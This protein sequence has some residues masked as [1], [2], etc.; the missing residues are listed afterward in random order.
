M[1]IALLNLPLDNNYGGNLQRF[2][3][4]RT[5]QKMGY[6]I[7]FLFCVPPIVTFSYIRAPF[8]Y[9]KRIILRYILMKKNVH[10][11]QESFQLKESEN[12]LKDEVRFMKSH[13]KVSQIIYSKKDLVAFAKDEVFDCYIVGSDQVW[14]KSI[15]HEYGISTYFLDFLPKRFR[16]KR[17]A[18]AVSFGTDSNELNEYDITKLGILY[19]KFDAISLRESSGINLIKSYKWNGVQPISLIDPTFLITK[20]EYINEI[21]KV[22]TVS[23]NGDIFC[24]ILDY[25]LEKENVIQTL[26]DK[27][28]MKPYLCC[29]QNSNKVSIEQW[30][31]FFYEAKFIVTDS[32]HGIVFSIIFNK[33]FKLLI[34]RKRGKARFDSLFEKLGIN[35]IENIDWIKVNEN[36]LLQTDAFFSFIKN[37]IK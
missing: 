26:S 32:F 7:T 18:L 37:N 9:L 6:D 31:R 13:F 16:G 10:I 29:L 11:R 14:R 19:E 34:N 3:I 35:D 28:K 5:L 27:L 12:V 15:A 36:I 1:K 20:S 17:V 30:L 24:Y 8:V 2:A 23:L 33:P 21:N 22:Q 25:N 4:M